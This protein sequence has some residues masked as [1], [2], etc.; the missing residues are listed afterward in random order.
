MCQLRAGFSRVDITPP[1]GIP[2]A[3]YFVPRFADGVLDPLNLRALALQVGEDKVVLLSAELVGL[4]MDLITEIRQMISNATGLP[5]EAI[6][7]HC[8]H[9]HTGPV[10]RTGL[11]SLSGDTAALQEKY[12]DQLF[13]KCVDATLLALADLKPAKM[14]YGVGQAPNVAFVRRFRM[15]DGSVRTNPGVNNPDIVAPIGDV[16]ERVSVIRFD[17]EQGDSLVLVNFAN[18]PDVIGGCK[19]SGDWPALLCDTVEKVLDNTT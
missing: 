19:I 13:R 5:V 16:D 3:G 12:I 9:T 7:I 10:A 17:R 14:G 11:T 8:S 18:H 15:K 1:L 2:V 6:Y 4:K